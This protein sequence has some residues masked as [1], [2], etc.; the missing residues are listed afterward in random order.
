[1]SLVDLSGRSE[2]S[3]AHVHMSLFGARI[4]GMVLKWHTVVLECAVDSCDHVAGT[5][6]PS[7][8]KQGVPIGASPNLPCACKRTFKQLAHMAC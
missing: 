8:R 2:Q 6:Q 5:C 1:M 3:S 4:P 7:A